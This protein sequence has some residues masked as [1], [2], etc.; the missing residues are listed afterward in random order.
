MGGFTGGSTV[1]NTSA[2]TAADLLTNLRAMPIADNQ[3]IFMVGK[4][5]MGDNLGGFYRWDSSSTAA[6]DL[7]FMNV[8]ISNLSATGRWVRIF[9]KAKTYAQG[10]L[11]NNAGV[12]TMY[13][14]GTTDSSGNV[15]VN[16]TDDNTATG[17]PLFTEVW[18]TAGMA[19]VA[20]A[21]ANDVLTGSGKVSADLKTMTYSFA[22][23]N[24]TTLGSTL[25][26]LAGLIIPGLRAANAG[27]AVQLKVEGI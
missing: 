21:T 6:E 3:R 9:Q 10:I 8:V 15:T 1:A 24:S 23:G 2:V 26:A 13:L 4:S 19:S 18:I 25:L 14:P 11:V 17:N 27:V 16:L 20:A 12:K 5:A 22:R 7:T